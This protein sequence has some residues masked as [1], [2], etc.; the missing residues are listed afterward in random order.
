MVD[1]AVST[2]LQQWSFEKSSLVRPERSDSSASSPDLYNHHDSETL[3][4]DAP[5][6]DHDT[7]AL[8]PKETIFQE[9][10]LSSEEDLSPMDFSDSDFDDT[11]SIHGLEKKCFSARKM[12]ISRFEKGKSCDMAITVSYVSAGRPKVIELTPAPGSPIREAP[13]RSASLP[14]NQLPIAAINKLQKADAASRL[15]LNTTSSVRT[16]SRSQSRSRSPSPA[17]SVRRPSLGRLPFSNSSSKLN[18][19]DSSSFG[20]SST[21]SNSPLTSDHSTRPASAAALS[22]PAPRS[23][24]YVV[25]NARN[26]PLSPFPPLTPQSPG[27]HSFL[28][29]DP[30]ETT[31]TSAASPIIKS[32]PHKRLRSIS[33]KLSL[34]KIAITPSKKWD[35]RINGKPVAMPPTPGTPFTPMTPMT[36][37]PTSFSSP[38]NRLRR[39]S[40]ISR[41]S[42]GRGPSP[43]IP[44]LP[45]TLYSES[46]SSKNIQKLVPR[47]ANERE[48]TLE[49]PPFP[50]EDSSGEMTMSSIKARRI[51]KRKSLMDFTK[52]L[53]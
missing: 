12:S 15:S 36:A 13:Q 49:L 20:D 22:H 23:S 37:P 28:S 53:M 42:S 19:S 32:G 35:S 39:N 1:V 7:T 31:T 46:R 27:P 4:I 40:R 11:A 8:D 47:G 52:D 45:T 41:P 5:A 16:Q 48:P 6:V 51:R 14:L 30:Y 50:A 44:P 29:S 24:L 17:V 34:A 43:E 38:K 10:Y 2:Q 9:R 21:R 25:S 3:R 26:S 18:I 33:Q